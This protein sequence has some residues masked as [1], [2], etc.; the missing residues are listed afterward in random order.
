MVCE[1][2]CVGT[3]MLLGNIVNTNAAYLAKELSMIGVHSYYQIVVGDNEERLSNALV[4]AMKRSDVLVLCGGLGP[5]KDDLTKEV[6][7]KVIGRKLIL[8]EDVKNYISSIFLKMGKT[9]IT[10]N[11]WKQALIIEGATILHNKNGTAPGLM[12]QVDN[13]KIFLLPGPPNEFIPLVEEQLV[14]ILK[15]ESNEVL[16]SKMVKVCGIGE[17][18]AETM[19]EDLINNQSNPTIAPYAKTGEVH[20]RITAKAEDMN[21]GEVIMEPTIHELKERFGNHI[22]SFKEEHNLN[23]VVMDL[24]KARDYKLAVAESCTGGMLSSTIIDL[25]GVSSVY[26]E[27]FITYSN[28]SKEKNLGVKKETL[29]KYGAVSHETAKEMAYGVL[30]RC[31]VQASISITGIAGPQGG[32]S[33]KPVGL[34]YIGIGLNGIVKSYEN[35]YF[36]SRTKIRESAVVSALNLL[37][38]TLLEES[39]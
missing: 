16:Y 9:E 19:I 7:A 39:K 35:H 4:E 31:K 32:T 23:Q 14:P 34:V 22:Y 2:I 28:E 12:V 37:R 15:K 25:D 10:N 27:G 21:Q 24:L 20:F 11:N 6:V 8:D 38:L 33:E 30:E 36:G 1:I 29:L 26:Q 3:E 18:K 13:I 5:T 17:S